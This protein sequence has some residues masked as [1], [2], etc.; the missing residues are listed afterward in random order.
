MCINNDRANFSLEKEIFS[1][2]P[3]AFE[4][5]HAWRNDLDELNIMLTLGFSPVPIPTWF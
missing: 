5:V 3:Y 1:L 4:Y 2:I